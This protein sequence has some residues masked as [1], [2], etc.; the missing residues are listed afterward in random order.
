M[1]TTSISLLERLRQQVTPDADWQRFV[2]LYTPLLYYWARKLDLPPSDAADLVQD[3]FVLLVQKL[4][5]FVYDQDK[6]FRGWLRA[7]LRNKWR[8]QARRRTLPAVEAS[9]SE[10]TEVSGQDDPSEFEDAEYRQ[11]LVGRALRI[12]QDEFQPATWKACWECVV[13]DRPPEIVAA[14]LG[15]TVNAVYLA[16]SRVL[17]RLRQELR[18]LLD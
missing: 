2:R 9:T 4:P 5:M 7:I 8:E 14:E 16:K 3:V 15:L 11:H 17:R 6:S 1:H 13:A 10:Q 12:M 18:G